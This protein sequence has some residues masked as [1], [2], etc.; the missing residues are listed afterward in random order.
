M[1][2]AEGV[3]QLVDG[4]LEE[5]RGVETHLQAEVGPDLAGDR[6]V[7]DD[8]RAAVAG[9][10]GSSPV[11]EPLRSVADIHESPPDV[12]VAFDPQLPLGLFPGLVIALGLVIE[13]GPTP[14][15]LLSR[16]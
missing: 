2:Q 12:P 15:G 10:A 7:I 16:R 14:D 13:R 11:A 5:I 8:R 3:A 4:R 9:T 1:R 6:V